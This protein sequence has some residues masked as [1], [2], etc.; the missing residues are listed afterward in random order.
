MCVSE[1]KSKCD[2]TH[3]RKNCGRSEKLARYQVFQD[4]RCPRGPC[5]LDCYFLS[6]VQAPVA[7][8]NYSELVH[9]TAH[10]QTMQT[11]A[12]NQFLR[13]CY[14]NLNGGQELFINTV[15]P[16]YDGYIGKNTTVTNGNLYFPQGIAHTEEMESLN[17]LKDQANI[18]HS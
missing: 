13:K 6:H 15:A 14:R 1:P 10:V 7:L 16:A 8:T 12:N 2:V 5:P 11:D 17:V 18:K 4:I 3:A 9:E